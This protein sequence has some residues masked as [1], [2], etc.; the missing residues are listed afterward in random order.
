MASPPRLDDDDD[1]APLSRRTRLLI[2]AAVLI[3]SVAAAAGYAAHSAWR[4]RAAAAAAT[5]RSLPALPLDALPLAAAPTDAPYM[6]FRS[7]ALGETY[8]RVSL[9]VPGADGARRSVSSLHCDRVH[10]A[11]GRGICLQARRKSLTTYHAHVFD[12]N[13]K[14]LHST[15]LGGV[16]SRAR[17]S[18]DGALAAMTVFVSGHSYMSADLSTRTSIVDA[19]SG[20]VLVEDLE[21]L[22]VLREGVPLKAADFNFWGVTF[23][24]QSGRFYATLATAGKLLLVEGDLAARQMRV[25]HDDV[26]C[27]SLSPDESHI[28]FKRRIPAGPGRLMWRLH[29]LELASGKLTPLPGETRSVDDQVEWLGNR[30]VVYGL[31]GDGPNAGAA[32]NTW[33]LR[34]DGR[35]EPRLLVPLA[36]SPTV[37]R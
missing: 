29:V 1:R 27:P 37:I 2:F 7:T 14:V 19:A 36:F 6:L 32:T 10:F 13:F 30:E 8:G 24:R 18:P 26:E 25:I 5:A 28:A 22:P 33:A 23:A 15:A 16:P 21:Q 11:G 20:Q 35:G 17:M 12:R 4:A 31:P 34:V 9:E 3:V